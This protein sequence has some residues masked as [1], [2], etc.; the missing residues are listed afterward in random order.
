MDKREFDAID[1]DGAKQAQLSRLITR[2]NVK[3]Q[4][5]YAPVNCIWPGIAVGFFGGVFCAFISFMFP[6]F[7]DRDFAENF[8]F[9]GFTAMWG[10]YLF[11]VVFVTLRAFRKGRALKQ[12]FLQ[13]HAPPSEEE[14]KEWSRAMKFFEMQDKKYRARSTTYFGD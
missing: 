14:I 13:Y 6:G 10:V 1:K 4:D 9:N 8:G 2:F 5:Y 12:E 11:L 7:W 3:Y